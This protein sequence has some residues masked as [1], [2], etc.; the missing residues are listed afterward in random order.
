MAECLIKKN[1][2][3]CRAQRELVREV[4]RKVPCSSPRSSVSQEFSAGQ[5]A[6]ALEIR[7]VL[8]ERIGTETPV[9]VSPGGIQPSWKRDIS[10]LPQHKEVYSGCTS[11]KMFLTR[12]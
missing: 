7:L 4:D 3:T 5:G 1:L 12:I 10:L 2:Q 9:A 11:G 8:R 6:G